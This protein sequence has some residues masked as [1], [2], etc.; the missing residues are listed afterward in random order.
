MFRV[1]FVD[2]STV[3]ETLIRSI[4][5]IQLI[6]WFHDNYSLCLVSFILEQHVGLYYHLFP[7]SSS[8]LRPGHGDLMFITELNCSR[9][10]VKHSHLISLDTEV[11]L[12]L[13]V[14]IDLETS[15]FCLY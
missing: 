1:V 5:W 11:T 7:L 14:P 9:T 6:W 4:F 2:H 13:V 15:I 10:F 3:P 12:M 8:E